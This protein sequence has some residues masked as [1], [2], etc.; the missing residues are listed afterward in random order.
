MAGN[1]F[2]IALTVWLFVLVAAGS[3]LAAQTATLRAAFAGDKFPGALR[4]DEFPVVRSGRVPWEE[5]LERLTFLGEFVTRYNRE[6][7][8]LGDKL[9]IDGRLHPR[10]QTLLYAAAEPGVL[11][12]EVRSEEPEISRMSSGFD[13]YFPDDRVNIFLD[14]NHDHHRFTRISVLPTGENTC[15]SYQV[16]E[17]HLAFDRS[18]RK[19][20]TEIDF[21][22]AVAVDAAGW[23]LRVDIFTDGGHEPAPAWRVIGLNVVRYRGVHGEETTMW[24]PDSNR[25]AAPLYFG[26]LYLGEPP[27]VLGSVGL[28]PVC[29]GENQGFL[30]STGTGSGHAVEVT[31]LNHRGIF[32]Q[33]EFEFQNGRCDFKYLLDPHELMHSALSIS[34]DGLL[35]G[36]Y[37]F[38]W[39]RGLLLT[40][41]PTG[42]RQAKLPGPGEDDYYWKFCRYLLDRLPRLERSADGFR[43]VGEGIDIDLRDKENALVKLARIVM[44]RFDNDE[45]R[46]AGAALLLCQRG[47]MVSSGTGERLA[48]PS[49]G[50]GILRV[51]A[52]F[53]GAYGELLRDM[54]N[55]MRSSSGK[56]FKACVVNYTDGP[57]NT[58][59]WP[60]HWLTGVSYKGGIT[61][62]DSELGTFF[63]DG[64]KG[65][66]L[67]LQELLE[68]PELAEQTSHGLSEYFR[69]R[70]LK[71]F[72]VREAGDLWEM[73]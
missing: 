16:N 18:H 68:N 59:G 29:W 62:L 61:L 1:K 53:C 3:P 17:N 39:K 55:L 38:G 44:D 73:W 4:P 15:Q 72:V 70:S 37:E 60:H 7:S 63:I 56:P 64:R 11:R 49:G 12:L 35:W 46:L 13:H 45:Q 58:F 67:T 36:G 47:V 2:D 21:K 27:L 25:V 32:Q 8:E 20:K 69:E 66:L 65:N 24:C 42:R 40:H 23:T 28:G 51:G 57:L 22:P 33:G 71:D 52:A 6:P 9:G 54:V 5:N 48:Q 14:L 41:R 26:D 10:A 50:P 43:L 30:L 19:L 34:I 31:T